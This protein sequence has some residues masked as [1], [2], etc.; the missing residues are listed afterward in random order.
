MLRSFTAGAKH[1]WKELA[2]HLADTAQH[3][4]VELKRIVEADSRRSDSRASCEHHVCRQEVASGSR[5]PGKKP[6]TS[7]A[8]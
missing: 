8:T 4:P 7:Q 3:I 1:K 5:A 2:H 6:R